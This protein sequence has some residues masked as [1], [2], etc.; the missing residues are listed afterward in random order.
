MLTRRLIVCLDVDGGRVAKGT[1]FQQ[2]RVHGTPAEMAAAYEC[3]GADEIVF[4]DISATVVGRETV[5]DEV[6]STAVRLSI[7][8][9]VGGGVR[10]VDDVAATLRAGADKVAMNTA[11][12]AEPQLIADAARRFGAQC[13][14]VSIDARRVG[15]SWQVV[16]H[17][18]R[19]A[20][21]LDAVEWAERAVA[22]GAGE[23]LVTS[24]D[25][26][27]TQ[28]GYDTALTQEIAARVRVPVIASGG[29]GEAAH[30]AAALQSGADAVL[31]AGILHRGQE[32]VHSLK[33]YLQRAGFAMRE[34]TE[35][36][37]RA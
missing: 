3:D 33:F 9:T 10:S 21:A 15:N 22:L 36:A 2:L 29:A 35:I 8:L 1:R 32:S 28:Q 13:V 34:V 23:L 27:G 4:L 17:G 5:L 25:R 16:T 20:T 31:V 18:G 6:R 24:I 37:A 30:L 14:V 11:A 7:P 26:D 12:V 19:R